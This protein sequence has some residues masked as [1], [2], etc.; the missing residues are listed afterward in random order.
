MTPLQ[1]PHHSAKPININGVHYA[2]RREAAKALGLSESGL[3]KRLKRGGLNKIDRPLNT[4]TNNIYPV[5]IDNQQFYSNAELAKYLN[6]SS[7]TIS[8]KLQMLI[9]RNLPITK[10]NILMIEKHRMTEVINGKVY[11]HWQDISDDYQIGLPMLHKRQGQG[12]HGNDLVKPVKYRRK[13]QPVTINGIQYENLKR[14]ADRLQIPYQNFYYRYQKYQNGEMTEAELLQTKHIGTRRYHV[15]INGKVYNQ[16]KDVAN[17]Y[18]VSY[19]QIKLWHRMLR[20]DIIT[21]DQFEYWVIQG[22][23]S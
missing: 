10:E 7:Q 12:L 1:K 5:T 9:D 11:H 15:T 23:K 17:D 20:Q 22:H 18:P 3:S 13:S 19:H 21:Q 8:R 6:I 2:T 14:A 4:L 16:L